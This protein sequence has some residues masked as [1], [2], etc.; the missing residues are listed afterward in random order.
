M[1][2]LLFKK[3]MYNLIHVVSTHGTTLVQFTDQNQGVLKCGLCSS[4]SSSNMVYNGILV[5]GCLDVPNLQYVQNMGFGNESSVSYSYNTTYL[6][7][8]KK[9]KKQFSIPES[10]CSFEKNQVV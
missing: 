2:N 6:F 8:S 9:K 7:S 3:K 4:T 5:E 10:L 1:Y